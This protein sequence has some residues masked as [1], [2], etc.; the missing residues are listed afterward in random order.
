MVGFAYFGDESLGTGSFRTASHPP[1]QMKDRRA[2]PYIRGASL[3]PAARPL[4][5]VAGARV[6]SVQLCLFICCDG[7][8]PVCEIVVY[9]SIYT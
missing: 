6:S 2:P 4:A 5:V 8:T 7:F 1:P 9:F 3:T